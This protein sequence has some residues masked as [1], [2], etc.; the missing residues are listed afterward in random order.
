MLIR[1]EIPVIPASLVV[2]LPANPI[3]RRVSHMPPG[4][5]ICDVVVMHLF[6]AGHARDALRLGRRT[7]GE[8]QDS[9][10]KQQQRGNQQ[11]FA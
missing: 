4:Q 9:R 7:L 11:Q 5:D 3:T 6:D 10:Q 2:T 8:R 1:F